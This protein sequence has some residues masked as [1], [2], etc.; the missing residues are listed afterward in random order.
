MTSPLLFND[1]YITDD[2]IRELLE[3]ARWAPTHKMTEPWRFVVLRDKALERFTTFVKRCYKEREQLIPARKLEHKL[4]KIENSQA[5]LIILMHRD[6]KER[7]PEWEEMAAVSSAVNNIWIAAS[8]NHINGYWS[9]P[10]YI[11][12][13]ENFLEM[14]EWESCLGIFYLG[15]TDKELPENRKRKPVESFTRW[16]YE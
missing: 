7:L 4:K 14:N 3:A 1:E 2:E 10:F 12:N 13:M 8:N 15:K 6:E 5:I 11:K 9:T 16:L